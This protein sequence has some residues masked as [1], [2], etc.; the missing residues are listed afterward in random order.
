ML[1]Q[2]EARDDIETERLGLLDHPLP[3]VDENEPT[4]SMPR[5][6]AEALRW[7]KTLVRYDGFV[8]AQTSPSKTSKQA[9]LPSRRRL[10]MNSPG[11]SARRRRQKPLDLE[12][13]VAGE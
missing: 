12:G 9:C 1:K 10:W 3:F 7:Q 4:M 11:V 8:W 6:N 5:E 2:A 13:P